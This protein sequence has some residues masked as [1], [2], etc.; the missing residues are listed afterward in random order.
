[1]CATDLGQEG[2]DLTR[3]FA[4]WIAETEYEQLSADTLKSARERL[5]DTVG[6]MLS[7]RDG[8]AYAENLLRAAASLGEGTCSP[9]GPYGKCGF[10]AARA[11]MLNAAFAHAAELDD[12]HKFAG[13]HAGAVV[14]PT[15]LAI[16]AEEGASGR[17]ILTAVVLGY[18][19]IYRL[20]V[21]QSPE[22]ID[23]GF[24]PSA[25][26]GAVGAMAAAGKLLRC[27][28]VQLANGLGMAGLFTSGLMEATVS[29]QQSKCVMVG[30]AALN[31]ISSAYLARE[32]LEGTATV[33][34]GRNGLFRAMGKWVDPSEVCKDL[35]SPF[36]IADTYN[37]FYPTCRH[38]QPAIEAVINMAKR[39]HMDERQVKSVEVGTHRVAWELTGRI[40]APADSGEAKFSI[41]YGVAAALIDHGFGVRHLKEEVY[42]D[43]RYTT[44][45][46]RVVTSVDE[47]VDGV[48]PKKRGARVKII[49]E[50]GTEYQEDC[51]NLKGSPL[52]PVGFEEL[53]AKFVHAATGLLTEDAIR[54][55]LERCARF[56]EETNI[57]DFLSLL[58][59]RPGGRGRLPYLKQQSEEER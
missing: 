22:L 28:R 13:V 53:E 23:R 7:G 2:K 18:E 49:M 58:H 47:E 34:E 16:G 30:N 14:I 11:A 40:H 54:E 43:L 25:V 19:V 39:Y 27:N 29:G 32:N 45:A 46:R 57:N 36:L 38:A 1:M 52:N 15:A 9:V 12:G 59:W 17:E 24:H 51:Y 26:C 8:W 50:D 3:L 44:L 33:F 21:S 20:A 31:G 35:G 6:A 55:V 41:A 4:E 48:Y 10:P 42:T 56:D 5:L 37:K